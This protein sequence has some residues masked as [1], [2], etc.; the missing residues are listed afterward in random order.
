MNLLAVDTTGEALSLALKAGDR[1][2]SFHKVL[3]KPHDETLLPQIE[4]LLSRAG[5]EVAD[6]DAIA[7]ASGPGRFTGIR[8]GMAY[9]AVAA[10]RMRVPALAITRLEAAAYKA[11]GGRVCAVV[12]GYREES[13]HQTFRRRGGLFVPAAEPVWA[14]PAQWARARAELEREGVEIVQGDTAAADL[15]IP[16][17]LRLK[18]RK[19]PRFEPLYLK[20]AGYE[21][22]RDTTRPVR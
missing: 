1:T 3:A 9:A 20:P 14:D 5:L 21:S 4:K 19:L 15:L 7:A 12:G 11:S 13:Y 10:S 17:A 8:I 18:A 2:F 16:A 22:K 6:L